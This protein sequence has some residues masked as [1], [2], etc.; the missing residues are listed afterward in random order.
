[1]KTAATLLTLALIGPLTG[2]VAQGA[3]APAS[4]GTASA[5]GHSVTVADVS[6][7]KGKCATIPITYTMPASSPPG[8]ELHPEASGYSLTFMVTGPANLI[9][10]TQWPA[11][12]AD[13]FGVSDY[14]FHV[15]NYDFVPGANK[16]SGRVCD[17]P[18]FPLK[19]G[20]YSVNVSSMCTYTSTYDF[21]TG[22]GSRQDSSLL[23]RTQVPFHVTVLSTCKDVRKRYASGVA[24]TK[25]HAA[26]QVRHHHR[27][28]H[29]SRAA[30]KRYSYLDSDHDGTVCERRS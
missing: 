20:S 18:S 7:S 14:Q 25:K 2:L 15:A 27:K 10:D 28:P 16:M 30:Y 3:A 1:M 26:R 5:G 6:V 9:M 19:T 8:G 22:G 13:Y 4:A 24:D 29:V 17:K 12:H 23:F 11:P 21:L